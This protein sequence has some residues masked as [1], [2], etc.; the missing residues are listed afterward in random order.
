MKYH[1][2]VLTLTGDGTAGWTLSR[3][4]TAEERMG[5]DREISTLEEKLAEVEAWEQKVKELDGLLAIEE[6]MQEDD[7]VEADISSE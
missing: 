7:A 2:Q 5:I 6:P 3:V 4:G 1:A